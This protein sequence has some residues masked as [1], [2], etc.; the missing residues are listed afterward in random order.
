MRTAR[1]VA[2]TLAGL[3]SAHS[4]GEESPTADRRKLRAAGRGAFGAQALSR[5]AIAIR[6][7]TPH[8]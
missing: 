7:P 3:R 2:I 8:A 1:I 4:R 6:A 5:T